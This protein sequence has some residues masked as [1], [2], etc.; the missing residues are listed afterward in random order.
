VKSIL[1]FVEETQLRWY[2]QKNVNQSDCTKMDG[3]ETKYH[4][5]QRQT[6]KRWMDNVKEAIE[7]RG[8]TLKEI[9]HSA[10][11]L[12]RIAWRNFITDRP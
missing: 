12:D 8:S 10:L 2:G 11:F 3:V 1:Q 4:P 5:T 6:E 9:E 7:N